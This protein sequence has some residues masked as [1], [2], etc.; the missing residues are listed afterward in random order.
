MR[1]H[2]ASVH[3]VASR[4][5]DGSAVA[6]SR[7][8]C[9]PVHRLPDDRF[10]PGLHRGLPSRHMTFIARVGPSIDVVSGADPG[11]MS[12]SYQFVL[13][14]LQASPALISTAAIKRASPSS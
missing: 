6:A 11:R 1:S 7:P 13:S 3:G 9:R 2:V 4:V 12:A 5:G 10:P 14:G 8:F